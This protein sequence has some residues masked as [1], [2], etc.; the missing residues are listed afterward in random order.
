MKKYIIGFM[1]GI[2]FSGT[3]ALAI[4]EINANQITYTN[5]NNQSVNLKETIDDLYNKVET[6]HLPYIFLS[7]DARITNGYA[8]Q[9]NYNEHIPLI[10][11]EYFSVDGTNL[12]IN[13]NCK[14]KINTLFSKPA[15][16]TD[17]SPAYKLIYNNN[18]LLSATISRTAT[19][20]NTVV[21]D[22]ATVEAKTGDII[23]KSISGAKSTPGIL[24]TYI[25]LLED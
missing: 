17:N 21:Q 7:L 4:S 15:S 9:T 8:I 13:K 14:I 6:T 11:T 19:F 16:T 23:Q 25:E 10:N 5:K 18:D 1:I 3:I 12:I 2:V 22:S 24:L 20:P